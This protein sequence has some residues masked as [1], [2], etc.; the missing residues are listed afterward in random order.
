MTNLDS[1]IEILEDTGRIHISCINGLAATI[2]E[3]DNSGY[4]VS[5]SADN[6]YLEL[7]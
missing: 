6:T 1:I 2:E 4:S 5:L 7:E 3:L